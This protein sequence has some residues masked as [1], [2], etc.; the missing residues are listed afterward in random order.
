MPAPL[1]PAG[2]SEHHATSQGA[3]VLV[4]R[5]DPCRLVGAL[6]MLPVKR[7]AHSGCT[8][9]F[10]LVLRTRL[11]PGGAPLCGVRVTHISFPPGH[12][13]KGTAPQHSLTCRPGTWWVPEEQ[14]PISGE[15]EADRR[16][17]S[18]LALPPSSGLISPSRTQVG[19]NAT[20][21]L[22]H[23]PAL[24]TPA[25]RGLMAG[26]LMEASSRILPSSP[27]VSAPLTWGLLFG[28]GLA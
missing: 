11:L 26:C 7:S 18:L 25:P 12:Q 14:K 6:E 20:V 9:K 28:P 10:L 15:R 3:Y 27:G 8:T 1:R 4:G 5:G 22:E 17:T 19:K 21:F 24:W 23:R 13:D 2:D 16:T